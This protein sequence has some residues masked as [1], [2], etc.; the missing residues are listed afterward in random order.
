MLA[1]HREIRGEEGFPAV[2]AEGGDGVPQAAIER[3]MRQG[4]CRAGDFLRVGG[5]GAD[6]AGDDDWEG[7][8]AQAQSAGPAEF[9]QPRQEGKRHGRGFRQARQRKAAQ[10]GG[11]PGLPMPGGVVRLQ[12]L[13]PG[14]QGQ[15]FPERK[16][17]ILARGDPDHRF[18]PEGMER[19]EE[20]GRR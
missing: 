4:Q 9:H 20:G 11:V 5:E 14:Q 17:D 3:H 10:G 12:P 8:V 13:E 2:D 6:D 7:V 1:L 19:P 16:E 18:D 15:Q